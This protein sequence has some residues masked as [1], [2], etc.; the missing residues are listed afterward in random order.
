MG[1][2]KVK[3]RIFVKYLSDARQYQGNA[4]IVP[5]FTLPITMQ[6]EYCFYFTNG[7]RNSEW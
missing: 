6:S 7:G 5:Y 4:D 1:L 2:R 3:T